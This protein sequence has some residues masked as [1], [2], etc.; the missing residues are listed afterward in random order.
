[1]SACPDPTPVLKPIDLADRPFLDGALRRAGYPHCEYTFATLWSWRGYHAPR[2]GV[3]EDGW[4]VLRVR[5]TDGRDRYLSPVGTGDP[6]PAVAWCL[7]D[8][9]ATGG[10]PELCLVPAGI[11]ASLAG[12]F[13]ATPDRD[14]A[15]YVYRRADLADLPGRQLA[16]KRNHVRRFERAHPDWSLAPLCADDR[17]ACLDLATSVTVGSP[18]HPMRVQEQAALLACLE[19]WPALGLSGNVLRC[20]E[21]VAGF[22]LGEPLAE[23]TWV[24]HHERADRTIEGAHQAL[25]R[26]FAE[27]LTAQFTWI[28]REQDLGVPG[29][30]QAKS[31]YLPERLERVFTVTPAR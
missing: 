22:C 10:V 23:Q 25:C 27:T 13:V 20:G 17:G 28:D 21:R 8:L 16:A 6:R 30:R 1:M 29:L 26:A 7:A 9:V 14:N 3:L 12:T 24:V 19:A 2:W 31:S 5:G 18:D 4:V 11:A 15:D